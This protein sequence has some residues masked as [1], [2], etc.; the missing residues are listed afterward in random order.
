MQ[1]LWQTGTKWDDS[2]SNELLEHWIAHR[3]SYKHLHQFEIPRH[4]GNILDNQQ[5]CILH[6][7]S[8]SSER[9]YAAAIYIISNNTGHLLVSKTRV[10][11]LKKNHNTEVGIVWRYTSSTVDAFTNG[12]TSTAS[13]CSNNVDRF[14]RHIAVDSNRVSQITSS[15]S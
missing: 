3:T 9:A 10:T 8:D 2:V 6:G 7:F 13:R 15:N 1:R 14:H 11:P 4:V 5:G 12:V